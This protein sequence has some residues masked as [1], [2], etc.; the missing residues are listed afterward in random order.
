M[1]SYSWLLWM[2]FML[3][4]LAGPVGY[5]WGYR[6][7]GAPYPTYI[8]RRR[9]EQAVAVTGS[10]TFNHHAWGW[11]GDFIWIVAFVAVFWAVAAFWRR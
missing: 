2:G 6:G 11:G 3:F 10:P 1:L 4:F 9:G 8:Q 5:G 7:W